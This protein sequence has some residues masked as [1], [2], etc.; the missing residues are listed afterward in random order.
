[1]SRQG[2]RAR[3]LGCVTIHETKVCIRQSQSHVPPLSLEVGF[4]FGEPW[5]GLHADWV[6]RQWWAA[7]SVCVCNVARKPRGKKSPGLD[8]AVMQLQGRSPV[9]KSCKSCVIVC[10]SQDCYP[11][12]PVCIS[13]SFTLR[14]LFLRFS[15]RSLHLYTVCRSR[16]Q[17][18]RVHTAA[19]PCLMKPRLLST[20]SGRY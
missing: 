20:Q 11:L 3:R 4:S 8:S 12:R 2:S 9:G 19:A 13:S 5:L 18:A 14:P 7:G 10:F 15:A 6:N 16:C 1:M 17:A